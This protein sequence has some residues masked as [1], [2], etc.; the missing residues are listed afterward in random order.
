MLSTRCKSFINIF[1]KKVVLLLYQLTI[2]T[3]FALVDESNQRLRIFVM[4]MKTLFK[5]LQPFLFIGA[6]VLVL[7]IEIK[8]RY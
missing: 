1:I 4:H 5:I 2:F 3:K 8:Q 6:V 7:P